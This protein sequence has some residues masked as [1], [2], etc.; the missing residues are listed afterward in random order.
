[1]D[2]KKG[3]ELTAEEVDFFKKRVKHLNEVVGVD[4]KEAI[5]R[6]A[7]GYMIERKTFLAI[8]GLALPDSQGNEAE[9]DDEEDID[10]PQQYE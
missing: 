10:I 6:T 3:L 9:E 2:N 8:I 7:D 4:L 1:M 5:R